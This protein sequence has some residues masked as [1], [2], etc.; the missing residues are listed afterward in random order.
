MGKGPGSDVWCLFRL[1]DWRASI[2][3]PRDTLCVLVGDLI[4]CTYAL[5]FCEF[6]FECIIDVL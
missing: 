5:C 1:A 3:Y 4:V 2:L 6:A